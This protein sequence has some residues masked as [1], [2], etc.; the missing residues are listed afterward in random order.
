MR[1]RRTGGKV[2]RLDDMVMVGVEGK[3]VRL[4]SVLWEVRLVV[5]TVDALFAER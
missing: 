5:L 1:G 4:D 3:L 2:W